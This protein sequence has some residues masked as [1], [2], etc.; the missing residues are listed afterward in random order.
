MFSCRI[1]IADRKR[2]KNHCVRKPVYKK[3]VATKKQNE[4]QRE[5]L[6]KVTVE[7]NP[8]DKLFSLVE[9][10]CPICR[11]KL[12]LGYSTGRRNMVCST[13]GEEYILDIKRI[14]D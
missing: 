12:W 4:A 14:Y 11:Q 3:K 2:R 10:F 7:Y 9:Y 8:Y 6:P 1:G 13:Y 5:K